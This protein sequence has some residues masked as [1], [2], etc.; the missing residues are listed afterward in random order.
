MDPLPQNATME[1]YNHHIWDEGIIHTSVGDRA[2]HYSLAI[3]V[4]DGPTLGNPKVVRDILLHKETYG[5]GGIVH[6]P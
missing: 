2:C 4:S 3:H 5:E 1:N 6:G